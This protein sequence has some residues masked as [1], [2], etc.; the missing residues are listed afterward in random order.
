MPGTR[1]PAP[2]ELRGCGCRARPAQGTA[3][4]HKVPSTGREGET[5]A[6]KWGLDQKYNGYALLA[7][8]GFFFS[9]PGNTGGYFFLGSKSAS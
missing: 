9:L 7:E 3:W 6:I 4:G 2:A 1:P 8:N 5:E